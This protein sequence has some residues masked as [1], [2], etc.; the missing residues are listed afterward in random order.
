MKARQQTSRFKLSVKSILIFVILFSCSNTLVA[1]QKDGEESTSS[2]NTTNNALGDHTDSEASLATI[3]YTAGNTPGNHYVKVDATQFASANLALFSALFVPSDH[4]GSL[5]GDDLAALNA[6]R[7]TILAEHV[8]FLAY[9]RPRSTEAR[10]DAPARDL[11]PGL[12]ESP[13]PAC[14]AR[15]LSPPRLYS[16]CG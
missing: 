3:G 10:L 16:A 14:L 1:Q 8:P 7:D 12:V 13:V 15:A 6:R 9:H 5:T 2:S 11:D 4:G